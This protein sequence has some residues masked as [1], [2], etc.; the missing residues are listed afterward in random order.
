MAFLKHIEKGAFMKL[1]SRGGYVLDF[2]TS[3]FDLFTLESVGVALCQKYQLSKGKSLSAYINEADNDNVI[4]LLSDLL[5]YYEIHYSNEMQNNEEYSLL[6][7]KCKSILK[8]LPYD[9]VH[10]SQ[11]AGKLKDKFSSTYLSMQID[12]MLKMQVD[13]PTEAIGKA[14]ELIES[15]CKTILDENH[16][17]YDKSWEMSKL[18]S[19]TIK[20]LK[21][22]PE[23]IPEN[24]PAATEIK[25]IL[26]NL[27]VISSNIATLR[28]HYGSGHGKGAKYKGLEERH[29]KLAV[30]SSIVLV[31]FIWDTH[32]R[33][34]IL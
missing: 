14:K 9:N 1:F 27:R 32:E 6:Y 34:L 3:D 4:K 2:S 30:G 29:A 28:N 21:I 33:R 5:A 25:A 22:M 10:L 31:S 17:N 19:E 7:K 18:T 26:G 16:V 11:T 15:C 24:A 12:L 13:N 23:D 20:L 8:G